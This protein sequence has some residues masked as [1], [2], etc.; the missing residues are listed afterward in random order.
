MGLSLHVYFE[1]SCLFMS[2]FASFEV[3]KYLDNLI[4][5]VKAAEFVKR[6]AD[7]VVVNFSDIDAKFVE[8]GLYEICRRKARLLNLHRNSIEKVAL[9][10]NNFNVKVL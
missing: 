4:K 7:M 10:G 8:L 1:W 2:V 6:Y 5:V 3:G 9:V